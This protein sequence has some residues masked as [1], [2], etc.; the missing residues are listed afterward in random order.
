ME[1]QGTDV[2][3]EMDGLEEQVPEQN[4]EGMSTLM[5]AAR[6]GHME[7]VRA[8]LEAGAN[9]NAPVEKT[10]HMTALDLPKKLTK[11]EEEKRAH[12]I[13]LMMKA[14][15]NIEQANVE[16]SSEEVHDA[17]Q[18]E[19][20]AA[21]VAAILDDNVDL[22]RE[23]MLNHRDIDINMVDTSSDMPL[24]H[25]IREPEMPQPNIL[26]YL[27]KGSRKRTWEDTSSARRIRKLLAEDPLEY[28]R[29]KDLIPEEYRESYD[30]SVTALADS[31]STYVED[32]EG[33][34]IDWSKTPFGRIISAEI[35]KDPASWE[36]YKSWIPEEYRESYR[37]E[38]VQD[39]PRNTAEA[40]TDSTSAIE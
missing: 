3:I 17:P 32:A 12:L 24:I 25:A 14:G 30:P 26:E 31:N 9:I 19:V 6:D 35:A 36:R 8:L 23:I 13:A 21:L 22:V 10:P 39:M 40:F 11:E 29:L 4:T 38:V 18:D 34:K 27:L 33:E 16:P 28:D 1:G 20:R 15:A 37:P 2:V 7:V 5:M